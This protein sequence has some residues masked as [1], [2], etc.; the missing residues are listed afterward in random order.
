MIKRSCTVLL[1]IFCLLVFAACHSITNIENNSLSN[2][3]DINNDLLDDQTPDLDSSNDIEIGGEEESSPLN[4]NKDQKT[5]DSFANQDHHEEANEPVNTDE[6]ITTKKIIVIDAGHQRKA[7]LE[8]EPIGPNA[9]ETKPKVSAGTSGVVTKVKEYELNLEVSLKLEQ[10]LISRGYEVIMIRTTHDVDMSNSE[11][12]AIANDAMADAFIRIHANGNNDR[13][14]KGMLTI[15]PTPNNPYIG[16]LYE[17]CRAL[18][19]IILDNMVN[20]TGAKSRGVWETDTMSGINWSKVPVTIIEM[21][22]MTNPEE[23]RLMSDPEFQDKIVE[24]I[25]NGLDEYFER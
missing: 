24:G 10:E 2:N 11:R 25:A 1:F 5:E 3:Q 13:N 7:N 23:D 18:S 22:F 4:K 14:V 6:T 19:E 15:S 16:H 12:A 8:H 20:A 17:E 21:G 9:S